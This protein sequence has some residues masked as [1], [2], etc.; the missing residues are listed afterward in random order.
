MKDM[1]LLDYLKRNNMKALYHATYEPVLESI[2]EYGLGAL[3]PERINA[4]D[5]LSGTKIYFAHTPE[6]AES[7]AEA[8]DNLDLPEDWL[9][10]IKTLEVQLEDLDLTQLDF[11]SNNLMEEPYRTFEYIGIIPWSKLS[12]VT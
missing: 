12:L 4:W 5:G 1:T 3:V 2:K 6:L 10:C 9:Y 11:D 7:F 8:A